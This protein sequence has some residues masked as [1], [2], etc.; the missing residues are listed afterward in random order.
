MS[1]RIAYWTSGFEPEMEAIS[2]EVAVLRRRFRSSISWGL[3]HRHW[4]LL[5]WR[6][7]YCLNPRLHLLFRGITRLLEPTFQL[8]HIFGTLGD[9]FYLQGSRRRPTVLTAV[10]MSDPVQ[11]PLLDRVDRFVAECPMGRDSLQRMGFDKE[12]VRLIFPPVDLHRFTPAPEPPGP[13]TVLF[14]SSPEEA[15]WLEARG[16]PQLLE[17]AALRPNMR[18]RLLWRPWGNSL[19]RLRQ[20]LA[21]RELHN[22]EL[23]V[24]RFADMVGQYRAAHATVAPFTRMRQCKSAPNSLVESLACGRPVVVSPQVGLAEL[25]QEGRAGISSEVSGQ[26]LADSFDRIQADWSAFSSGAR[27]LA[28]RW[29]ATERFLEA[30][31]NLYQELI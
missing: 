31:H 23:V 5:S 16:I 6:R 7:G 4:V 19:P 3:S 27:R 29:F 17:A 28:E 13:F 30:Y 8:N 14:A 2:G 15:T 22:V 21:Q 25:V 10:M 20:M 24:G 26:A 1:P 11:Q 18:F 12:R 9:W